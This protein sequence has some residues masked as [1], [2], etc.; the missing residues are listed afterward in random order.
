MIPFYREGTRGFSSNLPDKFR[1]K[2][3]PDGRANAGRAQENSSDLSPIRNFGQNL[4]FTPSH[5]YT[6]HNETEVI[7]LLNRHSEDHIR[8][9]G[10]LHSWSRLPESN[11]VIV[12]LRH[13][14]GIEIEKDENGIWARV[15]AGRRIDEINEI[16]FEREGLRLAAQPIISAPTIGGAIATGT[17]GTGTP[18]LSHF[19]DE[20]RLAAYDREEGHAQIFKIDE[21]TELK[22][23]RCNLGCM[24]IILSVRVR[25]VPEFMVEETVVMHD[26]MEQVLSKK[27][28]YPLQEF[29]MVP[30]LWKFISFKR[31]RAGECRRKNENN[32]SS[33]RSLLAHL[34]QAYSYLNIDLF[35]NLIIKAMSSMPGVVKFFFRKLFSGAIIKNITVR[36]HSRRL[37][38]RNREIF[39]HEESEIFIPERHIEEAAQL[40][41]VVTEIFA[42]EREQVTALFAS[43]L[44]EEGLL[45]RL[46]SSAGDY[47]HH[48]PFVFL[49]MKPDDTLISM[50]AGRMEDCYGFNLITYLQPEKR[51]PFQEYADF[52]ILALARLYEARPHWGKYF[53]MGTEEIERIYPELVTFRKVVREYDPEGVFQNSFTRELLGFAGE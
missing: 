51:K 35:F 4:T 11:E 10:S 17:H 37:L 5:I 3:Y 23:A 33:G 40:I 14:S 28:E 24:G 25:C 29:L 7:D 45:K 36:D 30:H 52:I 34:Y 15:G 9:V 26:S 2:L 39:C 38:T 16:L 47:T 19:V 48:Y 20:V 13:F 8:V 50:S 18:S 31:R 43:K 46:E 1:M 49:P 27:S 42:G 41:R 44:R 32:Q 22:A 6:P 12:D 21:G 53:E